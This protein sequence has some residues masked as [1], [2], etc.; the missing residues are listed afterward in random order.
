MPASAMPRKDDDRTENPLSLYFRDVASL[1]VLTVDQERK[2]AS[3]IAD[4]RRALWSLILSHPVLA[5]SAAVLL[6]QQLDI[7]K[8]AIKGADN[9]LV[10]LLAAV[11]H[12]ATLGS[13]AL[14]LALMPLHEHLGYVD[15]DGVA[16]AVIRADL[17]A[18]TAGAPRLGQPE[19]GAVPL[20]LVARILAAMTHLDDLKEAFV[21]ANLRLVVSIAR[22]YNRTSLALHDLIQEGNMGLMKAVGRFD[23]RRGFRFSTYAT[24]WIRHAIGRA[25]ADKDREVR[26]PVHLRDRLYALNRARWVFETKHGAAP[27]DQDVCSIVGISAAQLEST[28]HIAV[29]SVPL[30]QPVGETGTPLRDMLEDRRERSVSAEIDAS[31]LRDYIRELLSILTPIEAD[32]IRSRFGLD[33]DELP[34]RVLGKR[35]S[36]SR[37]RIRQLQVQALDKLARELRRRG[38]IGDLKMLLGDT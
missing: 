38:I 18:V 24:W 11:R 2:A 6:E 22:W 5:A 10:A 25:I 9:D 33:G 4:Q 20:D 15:L 35:H 12:A 28:N 32:I 34:F 27:T 14:G 13:A 37:E 26:L 21:K 36:L 19:L 3:D 16:L 1:D 31:R 17:R 7:E 30:D 29:V 23:H 8:L